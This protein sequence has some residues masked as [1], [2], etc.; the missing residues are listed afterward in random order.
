M[1]TVNGTTQRRRHID[2][3]QGAP[4]PGQRPW[5]T[6]AE[7]LHS[8]LG[9]LV[10]Q[11]ETR[12]LEGAPAADLDR[13][14]EVERTMNEQQLREFDE[15]RQADRFAF[16]DRL[17]ALRERALACLDQLLAETTAA[18]ADVSPNDRLMISAALLAE[19]TRLSQQANWAAGVAPELVP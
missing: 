8:Y 12:Q 7:A 9:E 2:A 11:A 3:G 10:V 6:L 15:R 19:S 1:M 18:D 5:V 14:G 16:C 17:Q 4:V 13:E